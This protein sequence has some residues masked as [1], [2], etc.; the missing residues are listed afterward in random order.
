MVSENTC[1][2]IFVNRLNNDI[3]LLVMKEK[4]MNQKFILENRLEDIMTI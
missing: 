1:K 3:L 2:I 4:D